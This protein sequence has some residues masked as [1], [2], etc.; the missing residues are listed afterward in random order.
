MLAVDAP[1]GGHLCAVHRAP[2]CGYT[3]YCGRVRGEG[4]GFRGFRGW[5]DIL[6]RAH[7]VAD[8]LRLNCCWNRR[9]THL[10]K[11]SA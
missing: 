6:W 4:F 5:V 1:G 8:Q 11:S 2:C 10:A 9:G 7:D 3:Y